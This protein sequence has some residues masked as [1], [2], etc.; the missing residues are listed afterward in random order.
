MNDDQ[1]VIRILNGRGM[2]C[3]EDY[4]ACESHHKGMMTISNVRGQ[5]PANMGT[6]YVNGTIPDAITRTI[7]A[8]GLFEEEASKGTD[9]MMH[10]FRKRAEKK[11]RR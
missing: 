5:T 9:S 10:N 7:D 11:L 4:P 6:A 1:M 8:R 3:F 2:Q